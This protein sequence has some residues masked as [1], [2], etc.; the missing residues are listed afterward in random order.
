MVEQAAELAFADAEAVRQALDVRLVE[1][2]RLDQAERPGHGVGAAAPERE[3]GGGFGTAA[4]AGAK[5]GLLRGGG[6]RKE[7]HVLALWA[8]APGRMGGS[9]SR[10]S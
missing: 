10:S 2:S 9:R 3:F 5:P 8:S 1:R 7:P 6:G 4:Q